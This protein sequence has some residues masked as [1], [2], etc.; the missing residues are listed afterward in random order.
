VDNIYNSRIAPFPYQE[1]ENANYEFSARWEDICN[2]LPKEGKENLDIRGAKHI[3]KELNVLWDGN[4]PAIDLVDKN[5]KSI[6]MVYWNSP[7]HNL[8]ELNEE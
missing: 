3:L 5:G 4:T 6:W 7:S 1:V 2:V 8:F